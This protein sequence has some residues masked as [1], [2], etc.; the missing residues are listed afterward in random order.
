[1][2]GKMTRAAVA[3]AMAPTIAGAA[4]AIAGDRDVIREGACSGSSDWKLKLSPEDGGLE[5]E[6]EVDSNV[7]GQ[8]W[9]SGSSTTMSGSSPARGRPSAR[10]ARSSCAGSRQ[11]GRHGL[12]PRPGGQPRDGRGLR[13]TGIDRLIEARHHDG[14]RAT[15]RRPLSFPGV[16]PS[17]SGSGGGASVSDPR[18]RVGRPEPRREVACVI[19]EVA[20][21]TSAR[22]AAR[23]FP[24]RKS[25]ASTRT[26]RTAEPGVAHREGWGAP[27]VVDGHIASQ[28]Q[29]PW[30]YV[31]GKARLIGALRL[32]ASVTLCF[33]SVASRLGARP[34]DGAVRDTGR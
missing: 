6:F 19:R 28:R 11:Q 2:I 17:A 4:P 31:G 30:P 32:G 8:T 1:M 18:R 27:T 23:S 7:I 10:A 5:V 15:T 29:R 14:R 24:P 22:R 16:G 25:S 33:V 9:R 12:V 13:R 34:S 26:R 20:R 21:P 3:G